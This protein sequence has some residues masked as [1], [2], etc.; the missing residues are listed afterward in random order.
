MRVNSYISYFRSLAV[1]HPLLLHDAASETEDSPATKHFIRFNTDEVI[2]GLR[3]KVAFPCLG[4]EIYE[5]SGG[6]WRGA[7]SVFDHAINTYNDE[8]RALDITEQIMSYLVPK[9]YQDTL[10]CLNP[11]EF[12]D[13]LQAEI[14]SFGPIFDREF[15]WRCEF[16][17]RFKNEPLINQWQALE[18]GDYNIDYST[19]FFI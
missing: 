4:V 14:T 12:I 10:N 2:T 19:D 11:F 15:G 8:V 16:S 17:F 6:H 5:R 1:A 3:T 7:F 13:M 9:I 18:L